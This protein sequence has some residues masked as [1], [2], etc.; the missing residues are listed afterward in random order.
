[1]PTDIT[2]LTGTF[3][4]AEVHPSCVSTYE[5]RLRGD[6]VPASGR[7]GSPGLAPSRSPRSTPSGPPGTTGKCEHCHKAFT[8]YDEAIVLT[9]PGASRSAELHSHCKTSWSRDHAKKCDFCSEPMIRDITTLSG[10]WG[11]AELHPDCVKGYETLNL[12]NKGGGPADRCSH[13]HRAFKEGEVANVVTLPGEKKTGKLHTECQNAWM[14]MQAKLCDHC[15]KPMPTDVTT[16]SGA[17]GEADVHPECVKPFKENLARGVVPRK[18]GGKSPRAAPTTSP[19]RTSPGRSPQSRASDPPGGYTG[20]MENRCYQCRK[21]FLPSEAVTVLS[22][23]DLKHDAHL[24][25]HCI[26]AF[27]RSLGHICT[28][29]HKTISGHMTKL[30]GDFGKATLHPDCLLSFKR[31]K[32][33][34]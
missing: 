4:K 9:L 21:T 10:K 13:C 2:T 16:L 6:T 8:Q 17:W 30:S 28:W 23:S 11:T 31:A 20:K 3:G 14:M 34:Q 12:H 7:R 19:R 29:C 18:S 26:D 27:H 15:I 33:L 5:A 32:N 25:N 1:M 24:H 22:V